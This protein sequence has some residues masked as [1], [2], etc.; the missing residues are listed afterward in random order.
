MSS[1][2][3]DAMNAEIPT[4]SLSSASGTEGQHFKTEDRQK[5]DDDGG[6][7]VL[8]IHVVPVRGWPYHRPVR[9]EMLLTKC[10]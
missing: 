7:E 9:S 3:D 6:G 4:G 2:A 1:D 5:G 10:G 8:E